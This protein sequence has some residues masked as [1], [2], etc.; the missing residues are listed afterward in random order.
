MDFPIEIFVGSTEKCDISKL[1][2]L[3][4]M[5]ILYL[6][7]AML[8]LL[9]DYRCSWLLSIRHSNYKNY[10][11]VNVTNFLLFSRLIDLHS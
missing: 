8:Y 2:D 9:T 6:D 7:E 4:C 11:C 3:V 10:T 1:K 5:I